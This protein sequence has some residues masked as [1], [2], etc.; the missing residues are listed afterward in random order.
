[1][2]LLACVEDY[3]G[4]E[5]EFVRSGYYI[6]TNVLDFLDAVPERREDNNSL[7][8]GQNKGPRTAQEI[9]NYEKEKYG[10]NFKYKVIYVDVDNSVYE[11]DENG[12]QVV[13]KIKSIF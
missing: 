8:I 6:L 4:I 12:N 11:L 13:A 7:A 5:C 1:M 9:F 2:H 10:N 3:T